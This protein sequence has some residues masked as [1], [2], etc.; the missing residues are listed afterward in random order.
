MASLVTYRGGLRRI[1]FNFTPSGPRRSLRLG[2]VNVRTARSIQA[3]VET[4]VA[5]RIA[6]RPHDQETSQWLA[7]LNEKLLSRMRAVGLADGVGVTQTTLEAFLDRFMAALTVKAGTRRSYG[8]VCRNLLDYFGGNRLLADVTEADADAW[9][10]WLADDRHGEG[11]ARATISRQV[12]AARTIWRKAIRWKLAIANPFDGVVG[13]SQENESRKRYIDHDTIERVIAAAPNAQWRLLI[14]LA[15]YG[16][17]RCPS[18]HLGL[19]WSDIDWDR[20]VIHVR[21]PKTEHL[22]SHGSRQ[23]PLFPELRPLLLEVY[24]LAEPD[25][26]RVFARF[27]DPRSNLRTHFRRIIRRAGFEPWPRLWQNLRASRESELMREYDLKTVCA[28]IGNTPAVAAR[29]YAMSIDRDADFRRAAGLADPVAVAEKSQQKSQQSNA[30]DKGRRKTSSADRNSKPFKDK[31]FDTSCRE[32]SSPV[33]N[34][35][36]TPTG[37]EP[38]SPG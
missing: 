27:R 30:A 31:N 1:D 4:I 15:R 37:F 38:V 3:R 35:K 2:R 36:M 17:L 21:S 12:K 28:W 11:L 25:S 13:G 20:G 8:H 14:G 5:D 22:E 32:P 29:S 23:V 9:R 33:R 26:E 34:A 6:A 16:G 10:A 19:T 24:E 18:E 7:S